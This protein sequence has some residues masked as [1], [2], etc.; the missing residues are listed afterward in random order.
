MYKVKEGRV[1]GSCIK[2]RAPC[3][4]QGDK[5]RKKCSNDYSS[6]HSVSLLG[7][8]RHR[9]D[10]SRRWVRNFPGVIQIRFSFSAWLLLFGYSSLS[11]HSFSRCQR[12]A[13]TCG[14]SFRDPPR[15]CEE[16]DFR[17]VF[18]PL[19]RYLLTYTA[20]IDAAACSTA[21]PPTTRRVAGSTESL[22]A[23]LVSS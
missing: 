22:S 10:V 18:P 2:R 3:Q 5:S 14:E 13:C 1:M 4:S 12:S 15:A 8:R 17:F 11:Y 16:G 9:R 20:S 19:F 7:R 23:S 6:F 21:R